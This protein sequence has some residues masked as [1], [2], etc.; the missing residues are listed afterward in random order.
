MRKS[1][2]TSSPIASTA[3]AAQIFVVLAIP[4]TASPLVGEPVQR[5]QSIPRT[6]KLVSLEDYQT[7]PIASK[8][9]QAILSS[10]D[11]NIDEPERQTTSQEKLIGE[12]RR[13]ALVQANW[14]GEGSA[15][16][17]MPSLK[18]AVAFAR[19][20]DKSALLPEPM[21]LNSGHVSLFWQEADLYADLEFLGD[22]R[23]AYFIKRQGDKHKGVLSFD[24][25]HMP[26][27]FP[28][29]IRA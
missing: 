22:G 27:V 25:Q 9:T 26:P 2:S 19:L 8:V 7:P 5:V 15:A 21:L 11:S 29:L 6:T 18:Q 17:S 12:L 13:L 10:A 28:T 14:D 1:T 4:A 23:I 24:N 16:P 20:L 3:A